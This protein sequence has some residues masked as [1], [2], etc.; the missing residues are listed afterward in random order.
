MK[1]KLKEIRVIAQCPNCDYE[2]EQIVYEGLEVGDSTGI[3][4]PNCDE[5]DMIIKKILK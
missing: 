1:N 3:K 4:C 5:P 2:E